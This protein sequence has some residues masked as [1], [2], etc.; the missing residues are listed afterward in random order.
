MAELG[1][2]SGDSGLIEQLYMTEECQYVSLK[3]VDDTIKD[4]VIAN[5][6]DE[7]ISYLL[8]K[9]YD[10]HI[11]VTEITYKKL[12]EAGWYEGRQ[13]DISAILKKAEKRGTQ[14]SEKQVLFLKEFSGLKSPDTTAAKGFFIADGNELYDHFFEYSEDDPIQGSSPIIIGFCCSDMITLELSAAGLLL[15]EGEPTG[16]TVM[17]GWEILL[18]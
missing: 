18:N 6:S 5:C 7:F 4:T 12:C 3:K 10:Y 13:V 15:K 11:T 17:E 2:V 1:S 16:R 14:L 8:T 9:E